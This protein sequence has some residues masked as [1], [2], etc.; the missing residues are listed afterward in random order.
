M[1][2]RPRNQSH[3]RHQDRLD[4]RRN[5]FSPNDSANIARFSSS[6][7]KTLVTCDLPSLELR[8]NGLTTATRLR[9]ELCLTRSTAAIGFGVLNGGADADQV[10][11]AL[12]GS[13]PCEF[14]QSAIVGPLVE[15]VVLHP[16]ATVTLG[17]VA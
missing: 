15:P 1:G 5:E 8:I 6:K 7:L 10:P 3:G 12:Q 16:A 9:A 17:S 14:K 11:G 4:T 2:C 13:V